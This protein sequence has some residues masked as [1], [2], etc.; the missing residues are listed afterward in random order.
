MKLEK[1]FKFIGQSFY[2]HFV[3][4]ASNIASSDITD[5]RFNA[6]KKSSPSIKKILKNMGTKDLMFSFLFGTKNC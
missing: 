6:I 1:I 3:T 5:P 2:K 4:L